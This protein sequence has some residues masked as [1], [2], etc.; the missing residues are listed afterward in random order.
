MPDLLVRTL[1]RLLPAAVRDDIF[2]PSVADARIDALHRRARATR[3]RRLWLHAQEQVATIAIF[4]QCCRLVPSAVLEQRQA[5]RHEERRRQEWIPL[6]FYTLRHALRLLVRERAFT[7]TAVLT[8]ALG[9]GFNLAIFAVIEAVMLRPLPYAA[10]EELVILNHR[11]TRTGITKE[12]IAMGDYVDLRARQTAFESLTSYGA[13]SATIT[14]GGEPFRAFVLQAGPGLLEMLRVT[15]VLGRS[16][17]PDDS[18]PGAARVAIISQQLWETQFGSDPSVIGRTVRVSTADRQIVGVAPRGFRFPAATATDVIIPATL[19]PAAPANRKAGWVFAVARLKPGTT[20][21]QG[22]AHLAALSQAFE[23]EFTESNAGSLYYP[24]ALRDHLLGDTKRPLLLLLL[25]VAVV[26]VIAC[27]NVG[28]LLL[29]RGLSRRQEMSV[30]VALGAGRLRLVLQLVAESLVLCLIAGAAGLVVAYWGVPALLT[31]VP[32]SLAIPGLSDV[33]LNPRVVGYGLLVCVL[34]ALVFALLSAVTVRREHGAGALTSQTRVAGNV[35]TRRLT[36][37]L[38]VAEVALSVMLLIGAGLILRSFAALLAVDPGFRMGEVAVIDMSLPA[39]RYQPVA[40]RQAFFDRAFEALRAVPGVAEVGAA[41]VT[42]LTGNNWTVPF[43]RA[44]RPVPAGTRP[45]DVGWQSA[46]GGYFKTMNIPLLAGRLFDSRDAPATS[47]DVVIISRAIEKLYFDGES[48]VGK[49]IRSGNG[50]AEIV[51][52]V[53][54]IRRAGLTDAP[55]AD[56]YFPF[57][58]VPSGGITLF[59]RTSG[60][61]TTVLGS[62][63]D[64]LKGLEPGIVLA[65]MRTLDGIARQS[66][67]S[68]RLVL[69]LLGLFAAVA[70]LLATVGVYG[71]M[72]YVV[73]QRTREFGTRVALGASRA[74]ILWLV[75]RQGGTLTLTGLLVGVVAGLLLARGL[76][77][78][79]YGVST[80]DPLTIAGAI[81]AL[82]LATLAAS[83]LPARRAMRLDAARTLAGQ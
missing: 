38:I 73:S 50:T 4:M 40:S 59:I 13:G 18:K 65:Q 15:P 29:A 55:R 61:P 77:S 6:M 45:P 57:E 5:R 2:A 48:A 74:D 41:A 80:T 17:Q 70:L 33:G 62:V 81:A 39:D 16:L 28:N 72:S 68:T 64:R 24:V 36:S 31:L 22:T 20:I 66:I 30:R 8:L 58:R 12:F 27:A 25:A 83:Y 46:S 47:P 75:M 26:L 71:V 79:L 52:V 60:D 23:A 37:G 34:T 32:A 7:A 49:K 1:G 42:P 54:D 3:S 76:A 19:L 9:L 67:A 51:G 35:A 21:E 53:G 14:A 11:D 43:D 82:G 56:M 10:A 63:R 69:W 44:D 78:T